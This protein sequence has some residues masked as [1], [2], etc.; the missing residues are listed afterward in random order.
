MTK[1]GWTSEKYK[2]EYNMAVLRVSEGPNEVV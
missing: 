1:R 2:Q